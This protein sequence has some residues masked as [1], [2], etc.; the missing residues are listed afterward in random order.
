MML[1]AS[2]RGSRLALIQVEI[3]AT[4]LRRYFPSATLEVQI[5]KTAGDLNR[6]KSIMEL[7]QKG[8]FTKAVDELL[9]NG[10]ADISIH[11]MKDLPLELPQG[12][13]IAA[14][15]KR[16]S[17]YEALISVGHGCLD[18]LPTGAIV[19]TGSPRRMAQ[20][21][22]LR[23]DLDIRPIRGNV[24]TRINKLE[25]GHYDALILA[26]AGLLRLNRQDTIKERLSLED[27]TPPA[28]QGALAIVVREDDPETIQALEVIT[29]FPSCAAVEAERSFMET[30]GGGC[31][32]PIG[33][34]V[35]MAREMTL[36]AS[37][38]SPDGKER[39]HFTKSGETSDPRAFGKSAAQEA[40]ERGAS[41]IVD[42][43]N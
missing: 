6:D 29:H 3:V 30:I 20:L 35:Q 1:K 11:S 21:K 32:T 41:K 23:D 18:N 17:P 10:E 37:V 34:M 7:G 40:M 33:V 24:D 43:W 9:F 27:F 36:Y 8:V 12:L 15:P 13:T 31:S 2:T 28:G 16:D 14:V 25:A 38:L 26:E 39:Y 4:E 19:G 5:V 42:R 22:Y